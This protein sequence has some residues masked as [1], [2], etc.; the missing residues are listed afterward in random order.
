MTTED[1]ASGADVPLGDA[2]A[3]QPIPLSL[4]VIGP[5]TRADGEFAW[6]A[7]VR[8]NGQFVGYRRL[9]EI[10]HEIARLLKDEA[11]Y[12]PLANPMIAH[13]LRRDVQ[14]LGFTIGL[15]AAPVFTN[16]S[17]S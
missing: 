13:G 9:M 14:A 4:P 8:H 2:V 6:L 16:A 7:E 17:L 3:S 1:A 5:P 10:C 11:F 12:L 15:P